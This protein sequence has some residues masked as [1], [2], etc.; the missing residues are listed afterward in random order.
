MIDIVKLEEKRLKW[1]K[2]T[3]TEATAHSSVLKLISEA[4]EIKKDLEN[5]I[6]EP[7]EYADA[8][9]CLFDSAARQE[10]PIFP[11]EIFEAFRQKIEINM[12]RTWVKNPDNTYSHKK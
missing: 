9:M 5:G 8:L 6:R 7:L 3:F 11:E 12:A 4:E 1:S 10:T 2:E